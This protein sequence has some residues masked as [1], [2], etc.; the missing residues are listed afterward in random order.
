[1]RARTK[2]LGSF[3]SQQIDKPTNWVRLIHAIIKIFRHALRHA[4]RVVDRRKGRF[5]LDLYY[6]SKHVKGTVKHK[7]QKFT[8]LGLSPYVTVIY[9]GP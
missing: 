1:M 2:V 8:P 3:E 4:R 7:L 5:C 9:F 6:H